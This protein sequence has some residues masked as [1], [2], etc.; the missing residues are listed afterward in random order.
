VFRGHDQHGTPVAVKR[1]FAAYG[2][3]EIDI[4][5]F[6]AGHN[7]KHVIPIIGVGFDKSLLANFIIM[8]IADRGLDQS[9]KN[10]GLLS[11]E[12]CIAILLEIAEGLSEIGD[13]IHRDLKPQNVL[14]HEGA[15]K[16]SDLGLARFAAAATSVNTMR[17]AL[18]P[19]YAAPEQWEGERPTKAVDIYS[20]G[21]IV[22]T[23][24]TG[25]PPF[26]GLTAAELSEQ[27]RF[28]QPPPLNASSHLKRLTAACL[29]KTPALR[30]SIVSLR[31]Q[32][33]KALDAV[34]AQKKTS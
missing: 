29:V 34:Q 14:F 32:L 4:A 31:D 3:R 28:A 27:H 26:T 13:I 2:T 18:T 7:W 11:E 9:I 6:L 23:L 15:W 17:E 25:Q 1:L 10:E 21:C 22:F 30:P 24:L 20:L 16:L 8:P 33:H 12:R 19:Q 5:T